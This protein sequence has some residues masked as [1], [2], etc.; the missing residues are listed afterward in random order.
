MAAAGGRRRTPP[1]RAAEAVLG[2][3]LAAHRAGTVDPWLRRHR[4]IARWIDAV[5]LAPIAGAMGD[6]VRD[7]LS[8]ATALASLLTWALVE[9]RPDRGAGLDDI[10]RP[11]WLDRT[12]WRPLLAVMAHYGFAPVP[13]FRDRYRR[14]A[15]ESVTDNLCGLWSVG[16]STFYRYLDKGKRMLVQ[17][18]LRLP[19]DASRRLALRR[20]GQQ[21]A[22]QQLGLDDAAQRRAWH[23]GQSDDAAT[24]GDAQSALW[25]SLQAGD[26]DGFAQLLRRNAIQLAKDGECDAMLALVDP[27][28]LSTRQ[29]FELCLAEAALWRSRDGDPRE[30]ELLERALRIADAAGDG[31]LIGIAYGALGAFHEA[32]DTDRAFACYED[33]ADFLQRAASGD[34]AG[35]PLAV[36]EFARTLVRLAW[37]HVQR[38]DPRAR[39]LL[40][41]AETMR[42]HPALSVDTAALLDQTW[43]EYWR[44]AGDLALALRHKHRALNVYERRGDRALMLKTY[45]NLSLIYGET[46][47][48]ER[49]DAYS[50]KVLEMARTMPVEPYIVTGTHLNRGA[51]FFWQGRYD[52][53]IAAYHAGLAKA[54]GA[55]LQVHMGRARYNLAEAHYKR[56]QR[57]GDPAD[58]QAGDAHAAAAHRIWS[59][60]NDSAAR[61]ATAT[62]KA[63]ILGPQ[64]GARVDR[65]LPEE[66]AAHFSELAEVQRHRS[67]LALPSAPEEHVAAHLAIARAYLAIST[68]EREAALALVQ[69]HDLGE[70]FAAEFEALHSTFHRELTREQNEAVRWHQLADGLLSDERRIA[71]LEH[72]FRENSIQKSVYASLCGVGLATASKHLTTLTERGLLVQSGKGP[73]TRYRLPG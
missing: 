59:A 38:S 4:R 27:A 1:P 37:L 16:P 62:L 22:Y 32:R 49:A 34:A 8:R 7:D 24:K 73:S 13:D 66:F 3:L 55:G 54:E 70:R 14:G 60:E 2:S 63:E 69:R 19:S 10:D 67:A 23:H 39:A 45:V 46:K 33:A 65:L 12:S 29:R 18:L 57:S 40:D 35:D 43:G 17:E 44:R 68:K 41:K 30:R 47:D 5:L 72:L 71:V 26:A 56:F 58:E 52:E 28:Q 11:A 6:V 36:E 25:H 61:E 20:I 51:N 64:D 50:L 31:L 21:H 9:L 53:A 48:F 15:E 42:A